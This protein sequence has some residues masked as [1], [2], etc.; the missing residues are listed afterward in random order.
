MG[1]LRPYRGKKSQAIRNSIVLKRG[2][3][4]LE[5][6][7]SGLGTGAGKIKVGDGTT[8]YENLPYFVGDGAGTVKSINHINPDESGNVTLSTVPYAEN[9]VSPDNI[10]QNDTFIFRTAGGDVDLESGESDLDVIKGNCVIDGATGE[11]S[12]ATPTYFKALGFNQFDKTSMVLNGYTIN[13]SGQIA[14]QSGS[15]V[16][17]VHAV[18]GL[19]TGYTIYSPAGY[20]TRVGWYSE[21]PTSSTTGIVIAVDGDLV[22]GLTNDP[23]SSALKASYDGYL[24][25][26]VSNTSDLNVHPKWTATEDTDTAEY[27]ESLIAIPTK[28]IND[29]NLPTATYGFPAV[30]EV[31][32]ELSFANRTYTQRIGYYPY[33]ASNLETVKA[34]DVDYIYDSNV[35]FYVLPTPVIYSLATT[36]SS[37]YTVHDYGTEE[38]LGTDVPVNATMVY[39]QNLRDKLRRDVVTISKQNLSAHQKAQVQENI[40]ATPNHLV[41]TEASDAPVDTLLNTIVSGNP[42]NTIMGANKRLLRKYNDMINSKVAT[43]NAVGPDANGNVNINRVPMADNL[44]SPDNVE[45]HGSYIVRTTAG[46]TDIESGEAQLSFIRGTMSVTGRIPESLTGN[47][48]STYEPDPEEIYNVPNID[49]IDAGVWRNSPLGS[50]SGTYTFVYSG[51]EWTY[52]SAAV[53]L[54]TTYGIYIYGD[55][56]DTDQIVISYVKENRGTLN[57]LKPVTFNATGL[58]V[59]SGVL[60]NTGITSNSIASKSGSYLY[61]ARCPYSDDNGYIAYD[62]NSKITGIG[63]VSDPA[64]PAVG[65]TVDSSHITLGS[66]I[67]TCIVPE[68]SINEASGWIVVECS[69]TTADICI[70]PRW[71]G[72]ED[73]DTAAYALDTITIPTKDANNNDLPFVS[74]GLP[75]VGSIADEINFDLK[76][77]IQRIGHYTYSAANLATVQALGVDYDYDLSH[78]FYVL[79]NP[80]II[81][82]AS[83]VS[84]SYEANDIGIE[85]FT[86]SL[87]V[88][89]SVNGNTFECY[90]LYGQNLRDKLRRDVLTISAQSLSDHEKTQVLTNIGAA[91]AASVTRLNNDLFNVAVGK[92][93]LYRGKNLGTIN[94]SNVNAFFSAIDMSHDNC[95]DL[96]LGDYFTIQDGRYNSVWMVASIDQYRSKGSSSM[97]SHIV[98][99]PQSYLA[100][101]NIVESAYTNTQQM[102]TTNTTGVSKNPLNPLY[103]TTQGEET[104]KYQCYYGSDMNQIYIPQIVTQMKT[105]LGTHMVTSSQLLSDT[106]NMT[107]PHPAVSG[108]KG[109]PSNWGWYNEDAILPNEVEIYGCNVWSCG[110]YDVGINCQKLPVFNF[111]SFNRFSRAYFWLRSVVYS[112]DFADA[113]GYGLAHYYDASDLFYVRPLIFVK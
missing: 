12:V 38:F 96:F 95:N 85:Y 66:S 63:F 56:K 58:N 46:S 89:S 2:E 21:I 51:S 24:C 3:I 107:Q 102:N 76:Q 59:C 81:N 20:I 80:I 49:H 19:D 68:T 78:I 5:V 67:S 91:S 105:V 28:D 113:G 32:D 83:T 33:S 79:T 9:L 88:G 90:H 86:Y 101:V 57:T 23:I 60:N 13:S 93:G 64:T 71:S 48:T 69:A 18:G 36:V 1:H 62:P 94:S 11:I 52:N 26:A 15:Y 82:L 53:D 106:M 100:N 31:R 109:V 104:A 84:S 42:M 39:G 55:V 112:A 43:V 41:F 34:L 65:K 103:A 40:D 87:G 74:Y 98:L 27:S 35:I 97:G 25:I 72:E 70:H 92:N 61:Y 14:A 111:I 73:T 77:Y 6:P 47:Y 10:H 7:E 37:A 22:T 29:N 16:C 17:Y 99:I 45:S 4:F 30:G 54:T 75:A 108:W 110:A 8:G 50:S 44:Y